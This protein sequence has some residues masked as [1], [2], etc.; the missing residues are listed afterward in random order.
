[1]N[2][3]AFVFALLDDDDVY[4]KFQQAFWSWFNN[5]AV[6]QRS[7]ANGCYSL[8][9]ARGAYLTGS[10]IKVWKWWKKNMPTP[11][12]D[13]W[14]FEDEWRME[15][16]QFLLLS[17][18]EHLRARFY[19][20]AKDAPVLCFGD[21]DRSTA[22]DASHLCNDAACEN[23]DHLVADPYWVNREMR[24]SCPGPNHCVCWMA[25]TRIQL[26]LGVRCWFPGQLYTSWNQ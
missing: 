20:M 25:D 13:T 16:C 23:P 6:V 24:R 5:L 17:E 15:T 26:Y 19:S 22:Y 7:A 3:N 8:V 18:R 1:M 2:K 14:T 10:Q 21:G 9:K 11:Y 12:N 4:G